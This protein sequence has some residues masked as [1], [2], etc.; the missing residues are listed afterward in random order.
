MTAGFELAAYN[1]PALLWP[2]ERLLVPGTPENDANMHWIMSGVEKM[3]KTPPSAWPRAAQ[4][5]G[6]MPP[7][8]GKP[9]EAVEPGEAE[10]KIPAAAGSVSQD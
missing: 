9:A 8:G 3:G 4:E 6:L 2:K 10:E 7:D 5:A 1:R